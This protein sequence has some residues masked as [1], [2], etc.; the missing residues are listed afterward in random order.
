MRQRTPFDH[1]TESKARQLVA[2]GEFETVDE[3][4]HEAMCI[5]EQE[6]LYEAEA[7]SLRALQERASEGED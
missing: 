6:D 1:I 2:L 4:W 5:C 7:L 3:A